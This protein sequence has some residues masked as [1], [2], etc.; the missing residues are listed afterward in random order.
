MQGA[1]SP[2]KTRRVRGDVTSA[3][4]A[5][6][7]SPQRRRAESAKQA[8][9]GLPVF[10]KVLIGAALAL[11]IVYM[12]SH[13]RKSGAATVSQDLKVGSPRDGEVVKSDE[14]AENST[15]V[16]DEDGAAVE[17]E[18]ENVP[19]TDKRE[20]HQEVVPAPAPK[21]EEIKVETAIQKPSS[22]MKREKG[23]AEAAAVA[24]PVEPKDSPQPELNTSPAGLEP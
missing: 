20:S 19:T 24:P 3:A 16:E 14:S 6:D 21:T 22:V 15:A 4:L 17:R 23:P 12:L 9:Q 10:A 13:F 5:A 1:V 7:K 2:P 8:D 11:T 18:P